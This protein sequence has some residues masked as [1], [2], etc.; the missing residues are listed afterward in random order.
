MSREVSSQSSLAKFFGIDSSKAHGDSQWFEDS[1]AEFE[2]IGL[3]L[4]RTGTTS[5]R[6]ALN[7]LGF[8]PVHHGVVRLPKDTARRKRS[9]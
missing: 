8:G 7:M 5:L 1:T 4:S 2:V 9:D 3:G 6:E